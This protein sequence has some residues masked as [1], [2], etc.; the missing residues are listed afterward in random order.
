MRIKFLLIMAMLL[1]ITSP[2]LA[3]DLFYAKDEATSAQASGASLRTGTAL[4][5]GHCFGK[6]LIVSQSNVATTQ[7]ATNYLLIYDAASATGTPKLDIS[8]GTAYLTIPVPLDDLE[9]GTGVFA[10]VV[11]NANMHVTFIYSQ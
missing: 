6:T 4:V 8:V 3:T 11:G 10:D 1:F 5:T 2:C 7:A 9:F